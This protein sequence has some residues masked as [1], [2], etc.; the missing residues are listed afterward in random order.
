ME[1]TD[2]TA[3]VA[4]LLDGLRAL[5]ARPPRMAYSIEEAASVI[6]TTERVIEGCIDRGELRCR[7]V[8]RQRF[9]AVSEINRLLGVDK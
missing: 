2:A 9:I 6:G 8:G 7:F 1:S 3:F 4:Q 5:Q